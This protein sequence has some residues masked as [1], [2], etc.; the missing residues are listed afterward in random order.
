MSHYKTLY[1]CF[2]LEDIIVQVFLCN[3][4]SW[5]QW[6][7]VKIHGFLYCSLCTASSDSYCLVIRVAFLSA[8]YVAGIYNTLMLG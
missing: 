4:I 8:T 3:T 1:C 2:F 6:E 7:R 5:R